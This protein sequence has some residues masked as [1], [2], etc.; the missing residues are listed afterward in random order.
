[1]IIV[2]NKISD[3][4][5]GMGLCE[6]RTGS[7]MKADVAT[8]GPSGCLAMA[9]KPNEASL[10]FR[11]SSGKVVCHQPSRALSHLLPAAFNE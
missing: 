8:P 4:G 6:T 9:L 11:R 1:M 5:E 7:D 3:Y 10:A 2:E